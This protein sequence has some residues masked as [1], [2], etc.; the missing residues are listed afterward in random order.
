MTSSQ[1]TSNSEINNVIEVRL[2]AK[3]DVDF[4]DLDYFV[5]NG[6][7][8]FY[9]KK[10]PDYWTMIRRNPPLEEFEIYAD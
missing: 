5:S 7:Q 10:Q 9:T 3:G 6:W 4:E 2:L 8:N 1:T